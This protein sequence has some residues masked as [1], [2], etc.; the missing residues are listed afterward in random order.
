VIVLVEPNTSLIF[1]VFVIVFLARKETLENIEGAVTKGQSRDTGNIWH[2][3]R[4]KTNKTN[5]NKITQDKRKKNL[6]I[7]KG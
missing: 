2:K 7:L 5:K 6:K 3:T 1:S 4:T